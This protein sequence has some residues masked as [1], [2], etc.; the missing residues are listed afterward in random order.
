MAEDCF[1]AEL[2]QEFLDG[3]SKMRFETTRGGEMDSVAA[4]HGFSY[5]A[6]PI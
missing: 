5:R 6:M 3:V 2:K 4:Y 1:R